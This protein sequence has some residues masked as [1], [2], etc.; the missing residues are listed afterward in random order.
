MERL[1]SAQRVVGLKQSK[2]AV[3]A[4]K[5]ELV[6]AA[7]DADAWVMKP[8]LALCREHGAEVV[9]VPTMKEL[10]KACKVEVSTACAVILGKDA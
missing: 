4:G 1:K 5:A 3:I 6:F 9:S 7:E 10:A 2:Q 8:F